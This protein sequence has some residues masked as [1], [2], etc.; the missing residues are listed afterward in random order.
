MALPKLE[1]LTGLE[2]REAK[3]VLGGTGLITALDTDF[4]DAVFAYVYVAERRSDP[5]VKHGDV[6]RRSFEDVMN[7]FKTSNEET[8]ADPKDDTSGAN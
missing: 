6:L 7:A 3:R 4:E 8:A 2:L 5:T 1:E